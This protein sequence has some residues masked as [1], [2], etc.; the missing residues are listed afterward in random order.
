VLED[1]VGLFSGRRSFVE[2]WSALF[3][4]VDHAET[5][6]VAAEGWDGVFGVEGVGDGGVICCGLFCRQYAVFV[7]VVVG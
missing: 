5:G 7:E 6:Y 3:G 1:G 4:F 2:C